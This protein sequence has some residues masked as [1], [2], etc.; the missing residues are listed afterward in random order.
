MS[1]GATL[2]DKPNLKAW[3]DRILARPAVQRGLDIP[4]P[5]KFKGERTEEQTQAMIDS[6]RKFLGSTEKN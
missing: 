3:F 5:N 1:A 2:D 6:A 4:E